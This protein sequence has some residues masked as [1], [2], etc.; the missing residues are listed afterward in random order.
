MPMKQDGRLLTFY[1]IT[2]FTVSICFTG[3]FVDSLCHQSCLA[4]A[5]SAEFAAKVLQSMHLLFL[6]EANPNS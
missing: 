2:T 5:R 6:T 3:V 1:L 4:L